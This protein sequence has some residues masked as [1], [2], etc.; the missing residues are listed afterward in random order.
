VTDG[1]VELHL[2]RRVHYVV[3]RYR[4]RARK[5]STMITPVVTVALMIL[6]WSA[7]MAAMLW[8]LRRIA[9]HHQR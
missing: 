4:R 9:R 3:Q 5:E 6:G 7:A 2:T 8:G 1:K